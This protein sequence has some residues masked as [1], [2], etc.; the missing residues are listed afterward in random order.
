MNKLTG[1]HHLAVCTSD[2]K[3]QIEFFT[4][5]LGMELVSLY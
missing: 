5:V 3:T 1:L 2:I 4:E